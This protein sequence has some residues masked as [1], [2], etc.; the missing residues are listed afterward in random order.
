[1]AG[2]DTRSF[3]LHGP[4]GL[5]C[6][7]P[8]QSPRRV[9]IARHG[10]RLSSIGLPPRRRAAGRPHRRAR[11]QVD[12]PPRADVRR[13]GGGRD[14]HHRAAGGRGRAAHRRR[15]ARARRRGDARPGRHV[16]RRRPWH[17][18]AGGTGRRARHGQFRH[19]GAAAVRRAGEP[20]AVR[21]DDRRRQPAPPSDAPGD[22]SAV[23]LRRP[24]RRA[25]GRPAAARR[26]GA[27]AR[28]CRS[29]T[30]CRCRRRR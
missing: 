20:S 19:R 4:A 14:P 6:R 21:G 23:G 1:M 11:R 16:A 5:T 12:Q 17:R 15:D 13:A 25:R 8:V 28:R 3:P 2:L 29:T 22:R 7:P 9:V 30:A 26:P 10:Y 24:L 18:R 27:D